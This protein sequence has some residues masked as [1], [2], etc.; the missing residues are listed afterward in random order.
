[1]LG[2]TAELQIIR[3][4]FKPRAGPNCIIFPIKLPTNQLQLQVD[5]EITMN[6]DIPNYRI[7]CQGIEMRAPNETSKLFCRYVFDYSPFLRIAPLKLE[8]INMK[9]YIAI[10]HDVIYDSEIEILKELASPDVSHL[11]LFRTNF[12]ILFHTAIRFCRIQ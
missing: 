9:P 2:S 10:Y 11:P 1:M 3:K 6:E 4:I 12:V 5:D 7:L 8:V